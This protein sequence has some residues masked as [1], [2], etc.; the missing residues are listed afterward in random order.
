MSWAGINTIMIRKTC[1]VNLSPPLCAN[2]VGLDKIEGQR[3]NI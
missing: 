3:A 2:A 1:R